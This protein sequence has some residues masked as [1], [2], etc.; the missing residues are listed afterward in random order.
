MYKIIFNN[1]ENGDH[2]ERYRHLDNMILKSTNKDDLYNELSKIVEDIESKCNP[3]DLWNSDTDVFSFVIECY[4][5]GEP[6]KQVI[7]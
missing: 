3:I 6:I 5:T 7:F 1:C 4:D 2:F